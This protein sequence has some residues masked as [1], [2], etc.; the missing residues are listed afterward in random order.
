L[1]DVALE[2]ALES[3]VYRAG[4]PVRGSV[5][6]I[7]PDARA[8]ALRV[9]LEHRG[10]HLDDQPAIEVEVDLGSLA[11]EAVT[12]EL[13][14]PDDA[15]VT[16]EGAHYASKWMVVAALDIP[17]RRDPKVEYPIRVLPAPRPVVAPGGA[18]RRRW[19]GYRRFRWFLGAFI[20]LS[21]GLLA[22]L[23]ATLG[24]PPWWVVVGVVA[25]GAFSFL[26]LVLF[27]RGPGVDSLEIEVPRGQWRFG[28]AVQFTVSCAGDPGSIDALKS[29]LKGEEVWTVS[30]GQASQVK[31]HVFHEESLRIDGVDLTGTRAGARRWEWRLELKL[32][33]DGPP[34]VGDEVRWVV[35]ASA[36]VPRRIDPR[37][38][39]P[40][41]IGGVVPTVEGAA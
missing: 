17:F 30:T 26:I 18:E 16:F 40:L 3:E 32:P 41:E 10:R 7:H 31:R 12:F 22:A 8:R 28:E 38:E 25:P 14:L 37:V 15:L 2:I 19:G 23:Y 4:D 27:S 11:T 5:R 20:V 39:C 29:S 13:A 36:H 1:E 9:G 6:G 33:P 35:S 24:D 21:A 34:S